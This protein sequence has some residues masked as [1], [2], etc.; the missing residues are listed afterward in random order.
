MVYPTKDAGLAIGEIIAALSEKTQVEGLE[1]RLTAE[2]LVA[3]I[4]F[5][6]GQKTIRCKVGRPSDAIP[7]RIAK[8]EKP[9]IRRA[10]KIK[11]NQ[12][13]ECNGRSLTIKGWAKEL[14][15]SYY[16]IHGRIKKTGN[17]YGLKGPN[18]TDKVVA[19]TAGLPSG[20]TDLSQVGPETVS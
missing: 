6:S 10:V 17:P 18:D 20:P 5:G 3:N 2:A 7:T 8:S 16:T 11:K 19:A 4:K 12:I 13:F 14:G 9:L 1:I 15:I